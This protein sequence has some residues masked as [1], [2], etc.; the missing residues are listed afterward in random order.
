MFD[1]Q[2]KQFKKILVGVDDARDGGAAF[3]YGGD[4]AKRDNVE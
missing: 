1:I 3:S 2:P 4:K